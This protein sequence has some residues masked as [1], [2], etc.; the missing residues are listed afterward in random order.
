MNR[1]STREH[2]VCP[3][4]RLILIDPSGSLD[5]L[6]AAGLFERAGDRARCMEVETLIADLKEAGVHAIRAEFEAQPP[7][8]CSPYVLAAVAALPSVRMV[9]AVAEGG[10]VPQ[11]YI[12]LLADPDVVVIERDHRLIRALIA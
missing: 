6:G 1:G 12:A 2:T 4:A 11:G 7:A 5:D 8:G 10:E 3:H 9:L